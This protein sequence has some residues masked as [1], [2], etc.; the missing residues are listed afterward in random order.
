MKSINEHFSKLYNLPYFNKLYKPHKN[1]FQ[2]KYLIEEFWRDIFDTHISAID[3]EGSNATLIIYH[4]KTRLSK[5]MELSARMRYNPQQ[6]ILMDDAKIRK[7]SLITFDIIEL[8]VE[9]ERQF[10]PNH[11]IGEVVYI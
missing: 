7:K 6:S 5:G 3:E 9:G 10:F 11:R 8:I 1:N 4:R 2:M